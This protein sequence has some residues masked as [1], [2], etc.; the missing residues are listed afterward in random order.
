MA[1][2][3]TDYQRRLKKRKNAE[4]RFRRLGIAAVSTAMLILFTLL[5]SIGMSALPAFTQTDVRIEVVVPTSMEEG[6][7]SDE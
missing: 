2:L 7:L 3:G 4:W 1:G 6:A 5:G